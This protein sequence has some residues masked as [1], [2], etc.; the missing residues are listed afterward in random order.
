MPDALPDALPDPLSDGTD[1]RPEGP[2]VS[3][4]ELGD[5]QLL[6]ELG[7][8]HDTRHTTLRHGSDDALET[9][10]RRT[11][12]LEAEYLRRHPQREVDADRLRSGA[13]DRTAAR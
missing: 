9:H 2:G 10:T 5:D 13:R 6:R 1:L 7:S 11:R 12:E 8:L 3:P 4:G